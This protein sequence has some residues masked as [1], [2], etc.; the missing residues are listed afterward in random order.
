MSTVMTFGTDEPDHPDCF[1]L[2]DDNGMQWLSVA[3]GTEEGEKRHIELGLGGLE[4][5]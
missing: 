5:Q 3:V 4:A 1:G 2:I